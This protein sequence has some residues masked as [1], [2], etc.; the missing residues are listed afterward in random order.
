MIRKKKHKLKKGSP[1]AKAFMAKLRT[2]KGNE[3]SG[4]KKH[5]SSKGGN[6]D[7]SNNPTKTATTAATVT[8]TQSPSRSGKLSGYEEA[9]MNEK[10]LPGYNPLLNA[11]RIVWIILIPNKGKPSAADL[12]KLLRV[13]LYFSKG[14]YFDAYAKHCVNIEEAQKQIRQIPKLSKI[15]KALIITDKQFGMMGQTKDVYSVAT[16]KQVEDIVIVG[17]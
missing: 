1:E 14:F 4:T 8:I 9:L 7:T 13:K 15:Y 3:I 5:R 10:R 12:K 6:N 16:K 17:E 2:S 11:Y